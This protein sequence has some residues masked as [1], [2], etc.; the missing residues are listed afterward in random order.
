MY[1]APR[2]HAY[3]MLMFDQYTLVLDV[4]AFMNAFGSVELKNN[5]IHLQAASTLLTL[6]YYNVLSGT[7]F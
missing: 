3:T 4:K 5:P 1:I 2:I 6:I 7:F